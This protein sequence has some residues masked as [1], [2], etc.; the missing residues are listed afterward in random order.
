MREATPNMNAEETAVIQRT[1][2]RAGIAV[3]RKGS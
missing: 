2:G 1:L 3:I